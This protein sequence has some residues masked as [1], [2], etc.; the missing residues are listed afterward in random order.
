MNL[1]QHTQTTRRRR[2]LPA[3]LVTG[4]LALGAS[5]TLANAG[6]I[7]GEAGVADE[8]G[9]ATA[10]NPLPSQ[11]HVFIT[12]GTVFTGDGDLLEQAT[13]EVKGDQIVAV[14]TAP[15]RVPEGART[16]DATGKF[17]TPG[18]IGVDTALGL[19]EIELEASTRDTARND[20]TDIRAGFQ[21]ARAINADSSLIRIQATEG[22]TT[23]AVAPSGGLLSGQVAWID[24]LQGDHTGI[25]R[26]A[27]V[28]VDGSLGQQV[29]GNRAEALAALERAFVDAQL[30]RKKSAAY[31]RNQLRELS[32]HPTDLE[33][34]YPVLDGAVPLTLRVQR[35]SDIL[36]ALA[37][38]ERL[39]LRL[40]VLGGAEA[41]KVRDALARAGVTVMVQPTSNLPQSFESLGARLENAA[42]LHE[43]GVRVGIAVFGDSHNVRNAR[44]EAG[45]AAAYGLPRDAALRAITHNLAVA[46]GKEDS[47]GALKGGRLANLVVWSG[48]P[49]ELSS[50]PEAVFIRGREIPPV[51]RQTLLRDRYLQK[52]R[53]GIG[54]AD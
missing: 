28:A 9:E 20:D 21:P 23:A 25:V 49:L 2:S 48:D 19:L 40:T 10:N 35:A 42:L 54:A 52:I 16:I 43:A 30:L 53:Q 13:I 4:L 32:A 51:S 37:L 38:A 26:E 24:L 45:I 15:V 11:T 7:Y 41:W 34:L 22:V 31:E 27:S 12:G 50:W 6:A 3:L 47:D 29:A 5:P 14:H 8:N 39:G 46:Y 17:I 1:A 18:L 33:A 44:Q 36:A